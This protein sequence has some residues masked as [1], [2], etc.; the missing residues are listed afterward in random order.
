MSGEPIHV[1][2][3]IDKMQ[4]RHRTVEQIMQDGARVTISQIDKLRRQLD[5][6]ERA[7]Q[8][9]IRTGKERKGDTAVWKRVAKAAD[10]LLEGMIDG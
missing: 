10:T 1:A 3:M 8:Y 5:Q 2:E 9:V 4:G 6:A 7:A